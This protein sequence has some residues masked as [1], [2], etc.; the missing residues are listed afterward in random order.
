M[1]NILLMNKIAACGTSRFGEGYTV[2]DSVASP[3]GIMVRSANLLETTFDPSLEAIARAGA[4]VNNI[5]CDRCA[6]EGIVVFNTP[7]AN[8]NA[9]KEL[10]VCALLLASRDIVAGSAWTATLDGH[11][12]GVAKAVEKG[13][14]SFAG[15]EILGKTLGIV[16]FGAIGRL[17]ADAA[18]AL[19]MNV[20]AYD[21]F[22]IRNPAVTV[23]ETS[24]E[25]L[26]AADYITL[27]IPSLPS[28]KGFLNAAAFA[29]MKDGVRIINL[30][31][32]D[33]AVNDD[34][35][36]A[37]ASGKV[38]K[39]V[40]DFPSED[41]IHA[42]GVICLPHLGASTEEAEDNCAM[43]AAD[44]LKDFLENGNIRNSVNYP[45]LTAERKG[46][47]RICLLC[48][49]EIPE[50]GE[51]IAKA[52]GL[53]ACTVQQAVNAKKNTAYVVID[54]D[55]EANTDALKALSYVRR[56]LVK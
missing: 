2:S 36:A 28:T 14:S 41:L 56:V 40:T 26:A 55:E 1:K 38:K 33:L 7:G 13:K 6:E 25:L 20:I 34:L 42:E 10:T 32:G 17:V 27:H 45:A 22:P 16:G 46:S 35:K 37:I 39:Y 23:C 50:S 4:G 49:G 18:K 5:P 29:K 30:A 52:A 21:A 24:D 3:D 48:S 11:E 15:C 54:T 43:M 12:L 31:R 8:A 44:E 19:G 53:T 9:V 51:E 47:K